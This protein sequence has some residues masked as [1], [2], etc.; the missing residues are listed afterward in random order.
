MTLAAAGAQAGMLAFLGK[1]A[2]CWPM[3]A[4]T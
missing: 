1:R 4:M 3:I 2:P